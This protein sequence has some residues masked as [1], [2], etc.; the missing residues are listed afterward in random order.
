MAVAVVASLMKMMAHRGNSQFDVVIKPSGKTNICDA[1]EVLK[2]PKIKN[3]TN[4]K[5]CKQISLKTPIKILLLTSG[6]LKLRIWMKTLQVTW[7]LGFG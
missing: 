4:A 5:F 2:F 7:S 6:S 3:S 1:Y